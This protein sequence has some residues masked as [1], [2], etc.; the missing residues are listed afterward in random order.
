MF[1]YAAAAAAAAARRWYEGVLMLLQLCASVRAVDDAG[2]TPLDLAA[3]NATAS[4]LW[5]YRDSLNVPMLS[6]AA[7]VPRPYG[8]VAETVDMGRLLAVWERFFERA[9]GGTGASIGTPR[10]RSTAWSAGGGYAGGGGSGGGGGGGG[11]SGG[12]YGGDTLALVDVPSASSAAAVAASAWE[13]WLDEASQRWYWYNRD[14]GECAWDMA[15]PT[16]VVATAS[17]SSAAVAVAAT[18]DPWTPR[19]AAPA[20]AEGSPWAR[21]V[22]SASGCYYWFNDST[23]EAVWD[24]T[25]HTP[26]AAPSWE[27]VWDAATGEYYWWCA[28]TGESSWGVS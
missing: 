9:L 4:L 18:A 8:V 28:E 22:D 16:G 11:D 10:R 7:R 6:P 13:S 2:A 17:T 24:T 19:A 3:D 15:E 1:E 23:G 26:D 21:L 20:E 5:D 14:T 25:G 27:Q 12:Y